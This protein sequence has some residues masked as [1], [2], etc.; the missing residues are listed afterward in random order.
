MLLVQVFFSSQYGD[1]RDLGS[2]E[3]ADPRGR[4]VRLPWPLSRMTI[5][6]GRG[7]GHKESERYQR[8]AHQ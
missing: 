3:A 7:S 1:A 5:E 8:E 2:E 6:Y 4:K